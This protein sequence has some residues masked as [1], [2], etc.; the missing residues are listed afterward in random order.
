MVPLAPTANPLFGS[1]KEKSCNV[2]PCGNGS[3]PTHCLLDG[4]AAVALVT[5]SAKRLAAYPL[6][7]VRVNPQLVIKLNVSAAILRYEFILLFRIT[8]GWLQ[9]SWDAAVAS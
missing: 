7:I 1:M 8:N 9:F 3:C 5:L 4:P 2:L 6:F